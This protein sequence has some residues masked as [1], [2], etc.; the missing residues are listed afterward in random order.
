MA[1]HLHWSTTDTI[2]N[3]SK[4][5]Y[6]TVL[7]KDISIGMLLKS[8]VAAAGGDILHYT[9]AGDGVTNARPAINQQNEGRSLSFQLHQ[10]C[11]MPT[12]I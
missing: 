7:D 9:H 8:A 1:Q 10:L 2:F 6:V 11:P 5:I 3:K 12:M 4:V